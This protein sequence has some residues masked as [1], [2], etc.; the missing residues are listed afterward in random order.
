MQKID[1]IIVGQGLAG[2]LLAYFLEKKGK[3]FVIFDEEANTSASKI[4][5]GVMNPITGRRFVKTWMVDELFPFAEQ[6][7]SE[8]EK[9]HQ[10]KVFH[11]S[12]LIRELF[13]IREEN[14][15]LLRSDIPS[16]QD[17]IDENY[18]LKDY[19]NS[20]KKEQ[21]TTVLQQ[22][23]RV[24]IPLLIQYFKKHWNSKIIKNSFYYNDIKFENNKIIY[25]DFL[26]E[27][28]VF[29]EGFKARF[30]PYFKDL[31]YIGA[32]GEVLL[33]K[34]PN[35]DLKEIV[36]HKLYVVPQGE[37]IYWIGS[38]NE[39]FNYDENITEKVKNQLIQKLESFLKCPFEIIEQKAAIRPTM[40]D[41]RPVLGRHSEF[42]SL[43]IFN[44]MGTKGASITPYWANQMADFLINDI[45]LPKEVSIRRME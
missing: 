43:A 2:T 39:R 18:D 36:K 41:R 38:S 32:K 15:W 25:N 35:L 40:H 42:P 44:G 27:N 29:C 20:F 11:P 23:A 5:A 28:V 10:I 45:E 31:K 9:E 30:N 33:V 12:R 37:D 16:Y 6:L 13:S 22:A 14:E 21:Y 17:Y 4:A 26:T 3:S 7:Y 34:I 8:I 1:F 24:D 19:Y